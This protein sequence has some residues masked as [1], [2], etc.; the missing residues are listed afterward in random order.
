[1]LGYF[2]YRRVSRVAGLITL[3]AYAALGFAGLDHYVVAP[4]SAHSAVMNITI[5]TEVAAATA[6]LIFVGCSA[7]RPGFTEPGVT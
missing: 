5:I 4:V 7:V 6:L 1:M 3:A 2:L